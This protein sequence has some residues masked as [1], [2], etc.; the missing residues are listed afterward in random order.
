M[1]NSKAEAERIKL[2]V[3]NFFNTSCAEGIVLGFSGG[4]DSALCLKILSKSIPPEKITALLIPEKNKNQEE[5]IK[6]IEKCGVK[7]ELIE[8]NSLLRE[9]KVPWK[10]NKLAEINLKARLRMLLL[11]NYANSNN[12]LVCGTG[13]K[14]E[15]ILGYFTKY[16]DGASDFLPLGNYLK[17]QVYL[18]AKE[19]N[20]P[21]EF[22]EKIPSADLFEGQSDEKE[23]GAKYE[24]ID[25][26]LIELI[27]NKK[28]IEELV[29]KEFDKKLIE[30][31]K[32][33]IEKNKHKLIPPKIL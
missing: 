18:L 17:T 14:S 22:I 8:L 21:K 28:T 10:Q 30:S 3:T 5:L 15:L 27:E 13:N 23:L 11:Y 6:F 12:Y 4:I 2:A 7:N 20:V 1:F 16:G 33:R 19:F 31:L 24:L 9:F 29:S 26:I 25:K 32:E